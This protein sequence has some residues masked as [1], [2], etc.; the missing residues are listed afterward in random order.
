MLNFQKLN[1]LKDTT[2]KFVTLI[3]EED[4]LT[5]SCKISDF[6]CRCFF[7]YTIFHSNYKAIKNFISENLTLEREIIHFI[8]IIKRNRSRAT[9]FGIE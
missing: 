2:H 1:L 9:N 7:L 3:K 6:T 5:G 4:I 8:Y